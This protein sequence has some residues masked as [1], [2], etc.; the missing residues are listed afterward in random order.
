VTPQQL[1]KAIEALPVQAPHTEA[2]D[3]LLL[4][5]RRG[6]ANQ[7][8]HWLGR[9][10]DYRSPGYY[11]RKRFDRDAAFAYQ[12]CGCPP[13]VLWLGEA[14]G[15]NNRSVARATK[16]ALRTDGSFSARCAAIRREMPWSALE[17]LIARRS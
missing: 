10:R 17:P 13:M 16:V 1:I 5:K 4:K 15:F 8:Q 3:R 12:H 14:A 11:G 6:Y 7:K 2:L 9:L